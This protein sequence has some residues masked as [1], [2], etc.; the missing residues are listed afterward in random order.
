MWIAG[1]GDTQTPPASPTCHEARQQRPAAPAGLHAVDAAVIVEGELLLVAIVVRPADVT[2]MMIF[3][4]HLPC[5]DRFAMAIALARP[6]IDDRG[7]LLAFPVHIHTGIE[8]VLQNRD[9]IAVA[10]RHPFEVR[11]PAFV[12]RPREVD[13]IRLHR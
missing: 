2:F 1:I 8:W 6:A 10:D 11:H 13:M 12:R 5:A 4:H 3:D 7:A 9:D